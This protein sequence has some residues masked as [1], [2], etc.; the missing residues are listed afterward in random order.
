MQIHSLYRYPVKSLEGQSLPSLEPAVRGFQDDRRW[1]F[2]LPNGKFISRRSAPSLARFAAEVHGDD[3][4]FVRASDGE[5]VGAVAGARNGTKSIAVT[6][7]DDQFRATLIDFPGLEQLTAT[8]GIPGARLVYM[9]PADIRPV[10]VRYAAPGDEVSF[11]DGFPYHLI[12]TAS[13]RVLAERLGTPDL[14]ILR[15]RP[16]IVVD[17]DE[18][19]SEDHWRA[20]HI[21]EHH[22]RVPK[23][24]ARCS[25]VSQRPG[26][27]ESDLKVLA[28]LAK[29]RKFGNKV[30]FGMDACWEGGTGP[31]VVG[32]LVRE[33]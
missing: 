29:F 33:A 24:C 6:V 22:F 10:D 16:N 4:H 14:S 15:F 23:P 21:G 32:D 8:L 20:L 11:A 7:W 5:T 27:G 25:M 9:G 31:V 18:A 17:T 2:V 1:M 26:S 3:L 13:L 30:L 28:E 19:F 12:T